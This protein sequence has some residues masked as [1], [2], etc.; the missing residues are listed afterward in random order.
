MAMS[1]YKQDL[2]PLPSMQIEIHLH[3]VTCST[4]KSWGNATVYLSIIFFEQVD[5]LTTCF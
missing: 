4:Q 5:A 1:K 3:C 2:L